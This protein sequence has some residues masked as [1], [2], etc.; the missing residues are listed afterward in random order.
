MKDSEIQPII[1]HCFAHTNH[2]MVE[3]PVGSEDI[4]SATFHGPNAEQR[5]KEY[6]AWRYGASA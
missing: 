3:R 6:A 1:R 4:E 2:W 5:A